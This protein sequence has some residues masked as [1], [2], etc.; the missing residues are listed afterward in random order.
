ME[1]KAKLV[2]EGDT[3]GAKR[4]LEETASGVEQLGRKAEA[5]AE[6]VREVA[7]GL[8]STGE[9]AGP[10]AT[11]VEKV[12]SAAGSAGTAFGALASMARGALGGIAVT[13]GQV[14]LGATF[15]AA[16]TALRSYVDEVTNSAP[17]IADDLD[18]HADLIRNI[19]GL[20]G[21]AAGAASSY[22]ANSRP[23]LTFEAQQNIGR[24]AG[25][26]TSELGRIPRPLLDEI[27]RSDWQVTKYGDGLFDPVMRKLKADLED[28]KADIIRW[29]NE[30]ADLASQ[31]DPADTVFRGWADRFMEATAPAAALQTELTRAVDIYKALAGDAEAASTALGKAGEKMTANGLAAAGAVPHLER[32]EALMRSIE[33]PEGSGDIRL[34]GRVRP[35]GGMLPQPAEI[36]RNQ[37]NW[38]L[39]GLAGLMGF[40]RF[41]SGGYTGDRPIDQAAGI[42]HGREFVVNAAATEKH[43]PL[44][45]AINAGVPGYASGGY[46]GTRSSA[47]AG[48]GLFGGLSA[49]IDTLRGVLVDFGSALLR[50]DDALRQLDQSVD[51][52]GRRFLAAAGAAFDRAMPQ[53]GGAGGL[54]APL[55]G[56]L[57]GFAG[58]TASAPPGLAWVGERGP[59]LVRFRG[60]ERVYDAA[61]SAGMAGSGAAPVI[62][63]YNH[64]G[65]PVESRQSRRPDGSVVTDV[66]IGTVQQSMA[67]GEF[68]GRGIRG[69]TRSR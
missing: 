60:G 68:A 36:G 1:L 22:G 34:V 58:G 69:E 5:A 33:R 53:L 65:E 14:A 29:R 9:H 28:G 63:I 59:E 12:A 23:R 11:E 6:P 48:G 7:E 38:A 50:G 13:L 4:A 57:L 2:I 25:D 10:A 26:F 32:Y 30:I 15:T 20:W 66:I 44:L 19:K 37:S 56:N 16:A 31:I 51:S 21:E 45:E 55:L 47:A 18:R 35:G 62:N 8:K 43:R 39:D 46:V 67:R 64:T 40:L 3:A 17:N 61:T 54:L 42:V 49:E 24:L 52:L 27:M 41:A